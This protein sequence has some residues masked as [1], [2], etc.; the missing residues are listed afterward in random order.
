MAIHDAWTDEEQAKLE[1]LI[2][3]GKKRP[4]LLASFDRSQSC[5]AAHI[6]KTLK[7]M[8][9]PLNHVYLPQNRKKKSGGKHRTEEEEEYLLELASQGLLRVEIN[10][11][12]RKQFKRHQTTV[13]RWIVELL[14]KVKIPSEPVEIPKHAE[15]LPENSWAMLAYHDAGLKGVPFCPLHLRPKEAG[16]VIWPLR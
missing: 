12:M 9:L 8:G 7:A 1:R 2:E 3:E 11:K 14:G 10:R 6:C 16:K 15:P 5:V 13:D 4:E